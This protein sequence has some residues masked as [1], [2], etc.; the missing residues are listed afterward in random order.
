ME[1]NHQHI[2][3]GGTPGCGRL[4]PG[5]V[6]S[7]EK[8]KAQGRAEPQGTTAFKGPAKAAKN[9]STCYGENWER[10]GLW[11]PKAEIK[12]AMMNFSYRGPR[13]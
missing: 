7:L 13:Q 4:C 9:A 1:I 8:Q 3:E 5:G 2:D 11:T 12:K 10:E 6:R